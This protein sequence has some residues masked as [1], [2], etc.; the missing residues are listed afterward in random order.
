MRE[1]SGPVLPLAWLR[2]IALALLAVKLVLLVVTPPFMDEAYYW[3]WG[4]HP[5]LSYFDHP[6]LNAWVL[7][8]SGAVFGWTLAAI[9]VPVALTLLGDLWLLGLFARHLAPHAARESFWLMAV[10]FLATPVFFGLTGLALPDH[11]LIFFGLASLYQFTVF[12]DGWDKG[13]ARWR[14][15]Y[16]GALALGLAG[17]SKY[18]GAL[19]GAGLAALVVLSP[20]YR[21]LLRN[22]H[23]YL[24]LGLALAVQAPV[25]A[26]NLQHGLASFDFI[27]SSRHGGQSGPA[28]WSGLVGFFL[29][30]VGLLGPLLLVPLARFL[31][32]RPLSAGPRLGRAVFWV[33][34]LVLLAVS[35]TT[36]V[37]FHWN[38][39]AYVGALPFLALYLRSR[40]VLIG[41][42]VYGGLAA[43]L[44]FVNYSVVPVMA[45]IS[46][47]DQTTAWSY[48]WDEIAAR[49]QAQA[50]VHRPGFIAATDYTLASQLAFALAD[51]Q[52]TS[53]SRRT[54]QF[55][56]WFAPGAHL[57]QAAILL[58]DG[59]RPLEA[60]LAALFERVTELE[61]VAIDRFG[62]RI[63]VYRIYLGEGFRAPGGPI[64]PPAPA[65]P[66]GGH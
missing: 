39:V 42:L 33:S 60:D 32:A 53:L 51:D 11:L 26:W 2:G 45:L 35:L 3:L 17:L 41:Q 24:A 52:V 31:G 46:Y 1:A 34:T 27:L 47:A 49:V 10:L 18:N 40:W 15:L 64:A 13:Q 30:M 8:G 4:Q 63:G 7:G 65:A 14:H 62:K 16:L 20:R 59:W 29:G 50:G 12:L 66:G 58:A 37:L 57:G 54:E 19:M 61:A 28:R 22:P 55:D 6:P 38:L 43:M 36:D 5:D 44:A 21:V 9:R 23:L 48:G 25:L 56:F